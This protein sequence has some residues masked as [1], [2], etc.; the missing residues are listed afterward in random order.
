MVAETPYRWFPAVSDLERAG[1]LPFSQPQRPQPHRPQILEINASADE[2]SRPRWNPLDRSNFRRVGEINEVQFAVDGAR[3]GYIF[4]KPYTSEAFDLFAMPRD[5]VRQFV[6]GNQ[7]GQPRKPSGTAAKCS[8]REVRVAIA[9]IAL[10]Q[11]RSTSKSVTAWNGKTPYYVVST[12]HGTGFYS[13]AEIDVF[14]A[15]IEPLR[16][17]Y[18]IPFGEIGRKESIS[19]FPHDPKSKGKYEKF[20]ER[21]DLLSL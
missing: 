21:W 14:A 5:F 8:G 16:I 12:K 19:L 6:T 2:S 3:H 20:R 10:V 7:Q 9:P 13:A 17:W 18:I 4:A 11:V 1:L 15:Y